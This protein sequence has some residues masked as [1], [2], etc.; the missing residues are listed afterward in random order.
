MAENSEV[1]EPSSFE[2][3]LNVV[4]AR[5]KEIVRLTRLL[6]DEVT[7]L[8]GQLAGAMARVQGAVNLLRAPRG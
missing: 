8:E 7:A 2:D 5:R 1:P 3:W 6:N 4:D